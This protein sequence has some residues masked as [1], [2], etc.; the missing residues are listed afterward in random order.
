MDRQMDKQDHV[1][2]QADTLTKNS[3]MGVYQFLLMERFSTLLK[4]LVKQ[5]EIYFLICWS[6]F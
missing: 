6:S 2:S 4:S 5:V 1:L 3:G